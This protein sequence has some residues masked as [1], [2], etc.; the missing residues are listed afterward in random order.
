MFTSEKRGLVAGGPASYAMQWYT[1]EAGRNLAIT[2]LGNWQTSKWPTR[3]NGWAGQQSITR[4][5]FLRADGGLGS[6]PIAELDGHAAQRGR[7]QRRIAQGLADEASVEL[8]REGG[9]GHLE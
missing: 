7:P 2:W 4:E 5:L 1:D 9:V 6:R 3:V 8:L